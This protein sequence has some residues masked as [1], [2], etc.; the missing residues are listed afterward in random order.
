MRV[1]GAA[2]ES[3]TKDTSTSLQ[4]QREQIE[5][6]TADRGHELVRVV[7]DEDT[8]G[9]VSPFDREHLGPWLTDPLRLATWDI[10]VGTKLDRV[11]RSTLDFAT[12]IK[13]A[14]EHGKLVALTAQD[15]DVTT[16]HGKAMAGNLAVFA[17]LERDMIKQR[18]KESF[19]RTKALGRWHGGKV[20][21]GHKAVRRDSGWYVVPDTD[22]GST[23][24]IAIQMA[25]KAI[26]GDSNGQIARWL[27]SEGISSPRGKSLWLVESVRQ[28]LRSPNMAA[29]LGDDRHDQLRAAL[30]RRSYT[31]GERVG[32]H[33]LLRVA[34][35]RQCDGPMYGLIKRG[36]SYRGYYVCTPCSIRRRMDTLEAF[37]E[38]DLLRQV[39]NNPIPDVRIIPGDDYTKEIKA[40]ARDIESLRGITGTESV[41]EAKQAEMA[42]LEKRPHRPDQIVYVQTGETVRSRW[43]ALDSAGR[44]RFLREYDVR[45]KSDRDGSELDPGTLAPFRE[46][47]SADGSR[48]PI[49]FGETSVE[50]P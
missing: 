25:D 26:A 30:R 37:T 4:G 50:A 35:C 24:A 40:I 2:R 12:L 36:R 19:E 16:P 6:W 47:W 34:Y 45:V 3:K 14:G 11:S 28:V 18:C 33:M 49:P 44:G 20:P 46:M 7:T 29:L 13:W 32:G 10:L 23:G 15:M 31:S 43:A 39:G 17:E 38:S 5:R 42:E 48:Q 21:Y 9:S 22:K 8:S 41:I 1:L 27:N